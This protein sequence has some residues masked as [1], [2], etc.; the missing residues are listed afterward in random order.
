MYNNRMQ[1]VLIPIY[2]RRHSFMSLLQIII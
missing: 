1:C 2:K